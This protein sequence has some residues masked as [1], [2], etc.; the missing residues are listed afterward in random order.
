MG[1]LMSSSQETSSFNHCLPTSFTTPTPS[2]HLFDQYFYTLLRTVCRNCGRMQEDVVQTSYLTNLLPHYRPQSTKN[3][4]VMSST[5]PEQAP[6]SPLTIAQLSDTAKQYEFNTTVPLGAWLRT[7][8]YLLK[9]VDSIPTHNN[10]HTANIRRPL[11]TRMM[12][13]SGRVTCL[14]CATSIWSLRN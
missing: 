12:A 11:F 6:T 3:H 5:Y 8:D 10:I 14:L 13:T 2:L 7:S 9:E 4:T 1:Q